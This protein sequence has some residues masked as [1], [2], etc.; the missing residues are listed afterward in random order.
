MNAQNPFEQFG[1]KGKILTATNGR[2]NEF[3]DMDSVVQIGSVLLDVHKLKIVGDAPEDTVTNMP[4]P[5]IIS[6]W[7]S[8]DPLSEK[9]YQIS[10]Y[11]F[12]ANNPI[13]FVDPDG[14]EIWISY[15]DN[16][17][18]KYENG[19]LYNSDG[20]KY[21]GKDKFVGATLKS[22]NLM[23][24]DKNGKVVLG[25]LSKSQN[26]FS[27]TN[28]YA[29]DNKGNDMK[30]T[31]AFQGAENNKGGEIHAAALMENSDAGEKLRNVAHEVFH[32]FEQEMGENENSINGEV[33]AMLFGDAVHINY[34]MK[35]QVYFGSSVYGRDDTKEGSTFESSMSSLLY[36]NY[37][38]KT[39]NQA[40]NSFKR[41]SVKN[42]N[43]GFLY[44]RYPVLPVSGN[45]AIQRF[46]PLVD[47]IK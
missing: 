31:L 42:Q 39:F 38:L 47:E 18:V 16:Q 10:P 12:V 23:N 34:M 36:G 30:G 3:H 14:R 35:T 25:N 26:I 21:A 40:L 43:S 33:Q 9:Y 1:D 4:N 45:P 20:S 29:K 22:L 41:G 5:T 37:G 15:G 13:L 32:G 28:T 7:L 27:F 8:P 11:A 19:K 6:R 46:Y 44:N 17:R 24:S 2:F